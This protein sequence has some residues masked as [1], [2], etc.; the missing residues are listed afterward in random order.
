MRRL[1]NQLQELIG[2]RSSLAV[3]TSWSLFAE[4]T[5]V[6]LSAALFLVLVL[7]LE[8]DEYGRLGAALAIATAAGGLAFVGSQQ[9]LVRSLAV[10]SIFAEEWNRSFTTLLAGSTMVC[11]I[12][13]ALRTVL[14]PELSFIT[15]ALILIAQIFFYGLA[16]LAVY[17]AQ[18]H[19]RLVVAAQ[20]RVA[21]GVVRMAVLGLF[22]LV[23][24]RSLAGWA[25]WMLASNG[26]AAVV[27][28]ALAHR[29]FGHLPRPTRI[30][31]KR[32]R[33][34]FPYMLSQSSSSLLDSADRPML[35]GYG[36]ANEA[37]IYFAGYRIASL[38]AVPIRA[39]AGASDADFFAAGAKSARSAYGLAVK[40]TKRAAAVGALAALALFVGAGLVEVIAGEEYAET[41]TVIRV[42][43]VLPLIRAL[44]LFAANALTAIGRHSTRIG[45][46]LAS[47]VVNIGFNIALIPRF[48]WSGALGATFAAELFFAAGL[49]LGLKRATA[50]DR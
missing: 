42:L 26:L 36:F 35:V 29:A 23:G 18:G 25:P 5:Q 37:G 19:R 15:F 11:A 31:A 50:N 49:W 4:A 8:P 40:T 17:A 45:M 41:T 32:V 33:D 43:S 3:N 44:Q 14:L 46:L 12:L 22:V 20:V 6:V 9:L 13:L 38:A 39:I 48:D 7:V 27:A 2:R 1:L 16:E 30:R 24:E 28:L 10:D 34:G 21:A 47:L